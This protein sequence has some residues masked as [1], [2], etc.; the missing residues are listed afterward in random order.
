MFGSGLKER[1]PMAALVGVMFM[2]S[3]GTFE[4]A[5]LRIFNKMPL[6]DV[7]VMVLVTA[8]TVI[9][10][11]LAVAVLTG[12][13][14]SALFY[15][16]ENAKRIRTRKYIDAYG[17]KHYEIYGPLFFASTNVFMDKFDIAGDPKEVIIDFK[18]SRIVDMSAIE[19]LN[20]L[21]MR[22][23]NAG[24]TIHLRHLSEDCK[25]LLNNADAL[26]DVNVLEDPTYKV[27]TDKMNLV[28]RN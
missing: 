14:L 19:T 12:V 4:W 6:S 8:I 21:T 15:A 10:H 16:W 7:L 5:S 28:E 2:V 9:T 17:I 18:E 3:I 25:R 11:N 13:I 22:Y 24:K 27:V 20:T 1:L 23:S 26:I